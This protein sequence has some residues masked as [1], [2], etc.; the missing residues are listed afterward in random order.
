MQRILG[1][2]YL[3]E[4]NY[5]KAVEL[6]F[7]SKEE[8]ERLFCEIFKIDQKEKEFG[9][10]LTNFLSLKINSVITSLDQCIQEKENQK[11]KK[12]NNSD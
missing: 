9:K 11:Q 12:A 10:A 2:K 6:L 4:K 5:L 1:Y 8:F 7:E 3:R